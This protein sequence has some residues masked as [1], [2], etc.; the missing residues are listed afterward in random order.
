MANIQSNNK[1]ILVTGCTRGMGNKLFEHFAQDNRVK[2]VIGVSRPSDKIEKMKHQYAAIKTNKTMR[3]YGV[4]VTDFMAVENLVKQLEKD[5]L[6]PDILINNAAIL[7]PVKPLWE[8]TPHEFELTMKTN[9]DGAFYFLKYF[10]PAMKD[11]K[12]SV[13]VNM[14][15]GW[16]RGVEKNFGVYCTS[17]WALEGLTQSAAKDTQNT[18][19]S[20]VALAPGIVDTDMLSEAN[21]GNKGVSLDQWIKSFPDLI[22]SITK[23]HSGQQLSWQ[24]RE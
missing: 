2:A 17:K 9:V 10:T 18:E 19:L 15:S 21:L 22:F 7:G 24:Q 8:V 13:I 12:N 11:K 14:S 6:I 20:I 4:D 3:V 23:Q 5:N 16:G 1:V